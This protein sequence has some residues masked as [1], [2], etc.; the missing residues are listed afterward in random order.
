MSNVNPFDLF[1]DSGRDPE[2]ANRHYS[3]QSRN[4]DTSNRYFSHFD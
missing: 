1:I 2:L 4:H 3:V